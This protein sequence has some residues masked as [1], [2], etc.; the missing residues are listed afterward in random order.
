MFEVFKEKG[1]ENFTETYL[2]LE[3]KKFGGLFPKNNYA[4]L[5]PYFI[6]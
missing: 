3:N 4:L 1:K 6:L 2:R 5:T